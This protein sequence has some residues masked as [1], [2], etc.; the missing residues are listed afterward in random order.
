MRPAT[1]LALLFLPSLLAAAPPDVP[2]DLTK[3]FAEAFRPFR[4]PPAPALRAEIEGSLPQGIVTEAGP[5]DALVLKLRTAHEAPDGRSKLAVAKWQLHRAIHDLPDKA[6]F[7]ILVYSE[8]YRAWGTGMQEAGG[9]TKAAAHRF[10]DELSP[11]GTTNICDPLEAAL[12]VAGVAP[13]AEP[14]KDEQAVDT[15]FLLS[16]GDPNRGRVSGLDDLLAAFTTHNLE[17]WIT[18]HAVGIGEAAGSSFLENL[19][20]QNG[21]RYV[22]FK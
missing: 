17:S 14:G 10:V 22:G 15:I 3:P 12:A 7:N 21:G 13:F 2:G 4:V 5:F 16:D 11:N 1:I 8:S 6:R 20:A 19:A 18:V 9:R